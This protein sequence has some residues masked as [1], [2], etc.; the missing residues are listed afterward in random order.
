MLAPSNLQGCVYILV[1]Y[2]AAMP[3]LLQE[4]PFYLLLKGDAA[5]KDSKRDPKQLAAKKK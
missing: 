5:G 1:T 2:V 4:N 3:L